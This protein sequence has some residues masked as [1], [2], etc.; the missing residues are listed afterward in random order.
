MKSTLVLSIVFAVVTASLAA[1]AWD[2]NDLWYNPATGR[3]ATPYD[4][5][6]GGGGILGTGGATD[7]NITCANCHIKGAPN[8][9]SISVDISPPLGPTYKPNTRYD[10]T[11][12]LKGEHLGLSGCSP[13]VTGNVNQFAATF[14]DDSGKL[15]GALTATYG[16]SANCPTDPP[17]AGFTGSTLTYRDCHAVVSA[18]VK[19]RA[20][21]TFSWTAPPPGSGQVTLY[22]GAVDG[23]C[24]MNSTGD[25]VKVGS[26][27]M[28]EGV[29]SLEPGLGP[30]DERPMGRGA[31][32]NALA[33][34]GALPALAIAFAA[35]RRRL[36]SLRPPTAGRRR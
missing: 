4:V 21:W 34:F 18:V 7:F 13:Y 35:R 20:S 6:P 8:Y 19:D 33:L 11:V 22:Y 24:M 17:A 1:R 36:A 10:L 3:R 31:N 23:D 32:T 9:G 2:G 5:M 29:A 25:D 26:L 16:S 27:V 30:Q 28:G 15:A 14:E 12:T